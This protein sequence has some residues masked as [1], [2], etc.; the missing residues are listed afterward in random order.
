MV[1]ALSVCCAYPQVCTHRLYGEVVDFHDGTPLPDATITLTPSNRT[2]KTDAF[3]K[4]NISGLCEGFYELEVTHLDCKTQMLEVNVKGEVYQKIKLEHHLEE[5]GEVV[6]TDRS[7]RRKTTSAAEQTLNRDALDRHGGASLG[8]AIQ[9]LSGVATLNTGNA[10]SKP[11]IHGLHS[12]RVPVIQNSVRMYDQEWGVEHAPNM[13]INTAG[14]IT[15][16]K[17]GA[18]LRYGGDAIGGVVVVDAENLPVTDTVYGKTL[19]GTA[20]NGRGGSLSGEIVKGFSGGWRGK[21]QFTLR[22]FGDLETPHYVLSNTGVFERDFALTFGFNTFTEGFHAYYSRYQTSTGILRAAHIG[23]VEDLVRAINSGEPLR[24]E[25]FTYAIGAP[26]QEVTHH[27]AKIDY[28]KRFHDLGKMTLQYAYQE[29]NRL[30]Y[31]IRRGAD[32]DKPSLDLKLVTHA[33]EAIFEVDANA[34]YKA[35]FGATLGYQNNFPNP[36]TGV[37]RLIPDYDAY[38]AAVF[39]NASHNFSSNFNADAG[40][41]YDYSAINAKKFYLKS[42]WEARHYDEDFSDIIT[43]DYGTQWLTN[44]AFHF[45]NV[46]ATAGIHYEIAPG[47]SW[48]FNYGL[49]NRNPNPAELFSDGLH[50]S[51]AIIE[52]GD[53]RFEK[54]T[55]HQLST[56]LKGTYKAITFELAPY[57]NS[58]HNFILLQ[59]IDIAY[60][61]RGAFPVW[62]YQQTNARLLGLDVDATATLSRKIIVESHFSVVQG[63]DVANNVPLIDMPPARWRNAITYTAAD[64]Y[65]LSVALENET[66]FRQNRFPDTN[67]TVTTLQDGVLTDVLVDISAPPKGYQLF[68]LRS[69]IQFPLGKRQT[70]VISAQLQNILNTTYRNYLNRLRYYADETGRNFLFSLKFNY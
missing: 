41:R 60:T 9:Q 28:F 2:V 27:L 29:N 39:I 56:S 54:E 19:F 65:K 20:S 26:R 21:V 16:V 48:R 57:I 52:L 66:V 3:G 67:F 33:L 38:N 8:E 50:H 34:H 59:P 53:I 69:E 12:S 46:A 64:F 68:H 22:R 70:M 25:P 36:D 24:I 30:E 1:A 51:A 6:V 58:I 62:E 40:I 10:I 45:H 31:D 32:K 35:T 61:I 15:V 14:S 5:L 42:L 7:I 23:N 37:R 55:A 13:D 4:F 63:D 47:I 11:V 44:P 18:A 17:G 43:G 49:V